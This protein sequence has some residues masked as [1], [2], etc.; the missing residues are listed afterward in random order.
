MNRFWRLSRQLL[1]FL[2]SVD[3]VHTNLSVLD[4]TGWC[5][6][7]LKLWISS[8]ESEVMNRMNF[9]GIFMS[10]RFSNE[11]LSVAKTGLAG[12]LYLQNSLV[13]LV[14]H[15][16]LPFTN[17]LDK[18][19]LGRTLPIAFQWRLR[20]GIWFV[21]KLPQERL[22]WSTS[23]ATWGEPDQAFAAALKSVASYRSSYVMVN[24]NNLKS[25]RSS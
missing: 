13:G 20:S 9:D 4:W 10:F 5:L 21:C 3:F 25:L 14:T 22:Q 2:S 8:Y 15:K 16:R 23:D 11:L 12:L 7:N 17:Q 24:L 19:A 18:F 1:T 6:M